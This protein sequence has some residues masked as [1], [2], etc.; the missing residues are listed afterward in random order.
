MTIISHD[1][2]VFAPKKKNNRGPRWQM[3]VEGLTAEERAAFE[4]LIDRDTVQGHWIWRGSRVESSITQMRHLFRKRIVPASRFAWAVYNP[5]EPLPGS[6]MRDTDKCG[7]VACIR[8][9]CFTWINRPSMRP[10]P[11]DVVQKSVSIDSV[12]VGSAGG[13]SA[14]CG[15][16]KLSMDL[17]LPT[18]WRPADA[19]ALLLCVT[20]PGCSV[21]TFKSGETHV[22]TP[23]FRGASCDRAAI[24]RQAFAAYMQSFTKEHP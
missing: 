6:L 24:L 4:A 17:G 9:D 22:Y 14:P 16:G 21:V 2:T 23:E 8:P 10:R 18:L 13:A 5:G 11:S 15:N 7:F 3:P 12:Y 19:D 20:R 1:R